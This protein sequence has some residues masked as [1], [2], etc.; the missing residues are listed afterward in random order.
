MF[1]AFAL[2]TVL[3]LL[4][5]GVLADRGGTGGD[6][7]WACR[8]SLAM[9]GAASADGY[10]ALLAWMVLAGMLSSSAVAASGRAVFRVVPRDERGLALGLRQTAVAGRRRARLVHAASARVLSRRGC[11]AVRAGGRDARGDAVA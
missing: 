2:G 10:T 5:W 7:R 3:A 11:R 6:R 8:G 4:A 9:F 1:T